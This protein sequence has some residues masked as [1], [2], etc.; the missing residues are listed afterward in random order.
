MARKPNF[1]LNVVIYNEDKEWIA[2]CLELD[3]VTTGK[4]VQKAWADMRD[5]IQAHIE[6]AIEN[7]NLEHIFKQAPRE[8]WNRIFELQRKGVLPKIETMKVKLPSSRS[9]LGFSIQSLAYAA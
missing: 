5:I 4:S 7:D 3:L 9:P 8:V 2:H 6:F 1:Q